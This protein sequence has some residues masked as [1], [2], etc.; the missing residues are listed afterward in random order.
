MKSLHHT[1]RASTAPLGPA[2]RSLGT[3]PVSVFRSVQ[4]R[5]RPL[6]RR[7]QAD[8]R[9]LLAN[10]CRFAANRWRLTAKIPLANSQPLSVDQ[11]TAVD[12][13]PTTVVWRPDRPFLFCTQNLGRPEF[14][15]FFFFF[16][17]KERPGARGLS[18][19]GQWQWLGLCGCAPSCATGDMPKQSIVMW[20][21]PP[22]CEGSAPAPC[23]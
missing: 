20:M 17:V 6:S 23:L 22:V 19:A 2:A 11:S 21:V 10:R 13:E 4:D 12:D 7:L 15:F 5:I 14:F 1:T 3:P 8:C 18:A 16:R 9:Q